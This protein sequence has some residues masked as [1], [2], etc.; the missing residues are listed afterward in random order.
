MLRSE[1]K[2]CAADHSVAHPVVA[3]L[4]VAVKQE[5]LAAADRFAMTDLH[6]PAPGKSVPEWTGPKWTGPESVDRL[7]PVRCSTSQVLPSGVRPVS[8]AEMAAQVRVQEPA[9]DLQVLPQVL[10]RALPGVH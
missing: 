8:A 9:V 5:L 1:Q 6:T 7:M 10:Q 2:C 4:V 3:G